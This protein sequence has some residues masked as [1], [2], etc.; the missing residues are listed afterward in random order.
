MGRNRLASSRKRLP[1]RILRSVI[2]AGHE[3]VL[4]D[5]SLIL[6]IGESN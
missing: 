5:V 3:P 2:T 4:S 6:E 1:D